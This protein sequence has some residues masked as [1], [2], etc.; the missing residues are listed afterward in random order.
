MTPGRTILTTRGSKNINRLCKREIQKLLNE[1]FL[2]NF[3]GLKGEASYFSDHVLSDLAHLS[4]W[5]DLV[6]SVD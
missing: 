1:A 5:I 3:H 6:I 4:L 2:T